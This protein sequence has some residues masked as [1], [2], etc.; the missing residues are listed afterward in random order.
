MDVWEEADKD[1]LL[2]ADDVLE[3]SWGKKLSLQ[4]SNMKCTM[5]FNV[6]VLTVADEGAKQVKQNGTLKSQEGKYSCTRFPYKTEKKYKQE[7]PEFQVSLFSRTK[8]TL[9]RLKEIIIAPCVVYI[10]RTEGHVK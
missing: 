4:N 9:G 8:R 6:F 10:Q 7:S 5:T 1:L 2:A 3:L